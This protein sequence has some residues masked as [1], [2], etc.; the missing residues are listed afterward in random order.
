MSKAIYL[1]VVLVVIIAGSFAVFGF[2][3]MESANPAPPGDQTP[4]GQNNDNPATDDTETEPP[5]Q[6]GWRDIQLTDAVTGQSFK[7]SDFEGKPVFLESFAVWCPTCLQQQK[8]MNRLL[9]LAGDDIVHISLDT[10][11]NED[12]NIVK[13]HVERNG[14]NWYFAVAPNEM[15]QQLIDEFGLSI[16]NAPGAPVVLLDEEQNAQFLRGGI[17]SA[18]EL[19]SLVDGGG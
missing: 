4:N 9:E 10:D 17:K 18:E 12:Q 19:L 1:A 7:I 15:T 3:Q 11:P 16:V 13:G 5:A 14:F 8:E 6:T 2:G